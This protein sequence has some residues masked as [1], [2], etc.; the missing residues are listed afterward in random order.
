MSW[1]NRLAVAAYTSPSGERLQFD[2]EDVS[3]SVTKKTSG[4]ECPDTNGTYVQDRGHSGRKFPL[5]AIFHGAEYDELSDSFFRLL[6]EK[7]VGRLEHPIYGVF[8][9]VPFGDITRNDALKTA[10]NQAVF[11]VTFWE[12]IRTAYPIEQVDSRSK[13]ESGVE[14]FNAAAVN[15]FGEGIPTPVNVS[16]AVTLKTR[17]AALVKSAAARFD[18]QQAAYSSAVA[19]VNAALT[20]YI[21]DPLTLVAQSLVIA[22]SPARIAAYVFDRLSAYGSLIQGL[23]LTPVRTDLDFR[24]YDLYVSG[25]VAGAALTSVNAAY[26]TKTE[27]LS[28]A[29]MVLDLFYQYTAWRDSTAVAVSVNDSADVHDNLQSAVMAS[30]A[31]LLGLSFTLKQEIRITL[32]RARTPIDLCAE[33][34]GAVDSKLD[35]FIETNNLTGS[36]IME[37]PQGR[38][39]VYYI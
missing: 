14:E 27:A 39:I 6:L 16:D 7:G 33:L 21:N 36:E 37:I 31:Y 10:A 2:Y 24:I 13:V 29:E 22:Q 35:F 18:V 32:D 15:Q 17:F 20:E 38:K 5:R 23:L 19:S 30:V 8:D 12:T 11:E 4:H 9:V 34:Y 26:G 28:A 3:V 25:Y 1:E